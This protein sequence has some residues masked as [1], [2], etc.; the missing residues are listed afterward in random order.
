MS[1]LP[2]SST[3]SKKKLSVQAGLIVSADYGPLISPLTRARAVIRGL[4]LKGHNLKG[5]WLVH[6]FYL[7]K[8]AAVPVGRLR[9][10][11]NADLVQK[12]HVDNFL[13]DLEKNYIGN[14]EDLKNYIDNGGASLTTTATVPTV[15]PPAKRSRTTEP[16][17]ATDPIPLKSKFC[18]LSSFFHFG[19]VSF[20]IA[21]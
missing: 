4:V 16:T 18:L 12:Q 17:D 6:W 7:G 3:K 9:V 11:P 20:I 1:K 15:S 19:K 5:H 14:A 21:N 2:P 10:P 13:N 8:T